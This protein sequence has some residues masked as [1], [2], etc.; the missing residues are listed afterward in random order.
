LSA[1]HLHQALI[2][3]L[4]AIERVLV[5][6]RTFPCAEAV[7]AEATAVLALLAANFNNQVLLFC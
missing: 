7:Q 1:S 2:A 5:A 4:G 6:M 3:E